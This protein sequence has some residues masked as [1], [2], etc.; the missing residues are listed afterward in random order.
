VQRI[1]KLVKEIASSKK[2]VVFIGSV[3]LWHLNLVTNPH[4][5]DIVVNSLDGLE[6]FGNIESWESNSPMSISKKRACIKREDYTIDIFI[7]ETL[8][9]YN[10]ENN[11]KF[12]TLDNLKAHI[13]LVIESSEGKLKE[14][15][16]EKKKQYKF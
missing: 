9:E 4:D 2:D 3:S 15:M 12:Q 14:I 5:I 6:V 10:V 11:I 13:E 16:I 8:P 1:E 7:E